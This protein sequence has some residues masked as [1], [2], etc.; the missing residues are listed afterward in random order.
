ML[1]LY[2]EGWGARRL[3]NVS[4]ILMMGES[5]WFLQRKNDFFLGATLTNQ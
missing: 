2:F 3:P 4:K 1:M 5:K